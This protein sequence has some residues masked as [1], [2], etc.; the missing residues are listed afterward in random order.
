MPLSP[1]KL[2]SGWEEQGAGLGQL[3]KAGC[4]H[5]VLVHSSNQVLRVMKKSQEDRTYFTEEFFYLDL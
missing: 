1:C 5:C 4:R 3:S 2:P